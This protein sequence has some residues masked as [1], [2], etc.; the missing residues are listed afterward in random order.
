V[1]YQDFYERID[2]FFMNSDLAARGLPSEEELALLEPFR[3]QVPPKVFTHVYKPAKTSGWGI[4]RDNLMIASRMLD[5]AGWVVNEEGV[6]VNDKTGKP[7]TIDFITVS[8]YLE[9]STLP[10]IDNLKK[11]GIK[12]TIRAIEASQ[13]TNRVG[14]Y[15][16]SGVI[17]SYSQTAIP[18]GELRSYWGSAS[19][20][21]D[22]SRNVAG[23]DDP[24]VDALIEKVVAAQ[25]YGELISAGRAL[26]RVMLWNYYAIPGYYPPGYRYAHWDKYD[27]PDTSNLYR[28][29]YFDLWWQDE[30]KAAKVEAYLAQMNPDSGD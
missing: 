29:G 4:P 26:D 30:E 10:F 3:D 1:L 15:D 18:G 7:L 23:I 24:V 28:S 20:K 13:Y 22:Y 27:F 16:L 17:Q 8:I 11:L 2:S 5:E 9:R 14:K 19:G 12:A 25:S 6:R 21:Q